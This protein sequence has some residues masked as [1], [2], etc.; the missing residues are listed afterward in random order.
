MDYKAKAHRII[1]KLRKSGQLKG[2]KCMNCGEPANQEHH[3][4][5]V[6]AVTTKPACS[7]KCHWILSHR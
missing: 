3:R 4:D 5:H 2:R 1:G 6:L 7:A